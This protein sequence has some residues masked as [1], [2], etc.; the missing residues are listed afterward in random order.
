MA[1]RTGYGTAESGEWRG[2][3]NSWCSFGAFIATGGTLGSRLTVRTCWW[4]NNTS[5]STSGL[6]VYFCWCYTLYTMAVS[7]S[8]A[9]EK[10][11]FN[12]TYVHMTRSF[13]A[14]NKNGLAI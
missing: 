11:G 5:W 8:F 6:D 1:A 9:F 12:K 10:A 3:R 2:C 13:G 7:R 4:Y 14:L